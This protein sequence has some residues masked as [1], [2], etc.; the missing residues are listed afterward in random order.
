[1][2][3]NNQTATEST[4]NIKEW[5][6]AIVNEQLPVS[7]LS[8]EQKSQSAQTS[9]IRDNEAVLTVMDGMSLSSSCYLAC[10]KH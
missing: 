10:R 6:L 9:T 4:R 8:K 1:M 7:S 2:K 5:F 3:Q